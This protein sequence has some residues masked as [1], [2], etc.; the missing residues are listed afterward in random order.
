MGLRGLGI[1]MTEIVQSDGIKQHDDANIVEQPPIKIEQPTLKCS[2]CKKDL[3]PSEFYITT[4]YWH[5]KRGRTYRCKGCCRES[6][7]KSLANRKAKE[8][9]DE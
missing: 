3:P 5:E 6:A 9:V 1:S 4:N 7:R 2:S 8:K